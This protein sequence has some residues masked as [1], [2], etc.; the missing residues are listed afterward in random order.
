MA[1]LHVENLYKS[2]AGE[3]IF[4]DITFS[5]DQKDKIGIIGVNGAGKTTLIKM[6]LEEEENDVNP[7]TEKRGSISKKGDLK[8][9]YL[10]QNINVDY[11]N[12][13][14]EELMTVFSDIKNDYKKIHEL[15][16]RLNL[17]PENFEKIMN[18][19]SEV[20]SRYEQAEGYSIEYKVKQIL[21]GLSIPEELWDIEIKNLSGGQK[22]RTALGKILLE[23]P[24]LLILD[25][26]TNHLDLLAIEWLEKFLKDY[27][28]AGVC[29]VC[30]MQRDGER[31]RQREIE[32]QEIGRAHV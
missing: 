30:I 20:S 7:E 4:K 27:N 28:K 8:I 14:F 25:E 32:R 13:I 31:E 1:L 29:S 3:T 24:E 2:F 18:E 11:N 10:S 9:G 23:E 5:I 15:T 26:P 16:L 19:L 6:I 22:S 17:E 12:T 21:N